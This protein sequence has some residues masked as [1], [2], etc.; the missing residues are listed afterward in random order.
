MEYS[1]PV[2]YSQVKISLTHPMADK[3]SIIWG[4]GTYSDPYDSRE[5]AFFKNGEWVSDAIPELAQHSDGSPTH[6]V[7]P[8]VPI[9]ELLSFLM[10]YAKGVDPASIEFIRYAIEA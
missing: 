2:P 1:G 9:E 8:Y 10:T 7:Y 4:F 3:V 6:V 5:L